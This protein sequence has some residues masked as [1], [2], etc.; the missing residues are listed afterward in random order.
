MHSKHPKEDPL[1][2]MGYEVRDAEMK[3]IGVATGIFFAFVVVSFA[4]GFG[5]FAWLNPAILHE[6]TTQ[7]PFMSNAPKPPYPLLQ[8]N[9]TTKTDIKELRQG[10]TAQL[11]TSAVLDA[12]K[13]VY[14][15]PIDRAIDLV[16]QRGLPERPSPNVVS[17]PK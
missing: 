16:A 3:T 12:K 17:G 11:T 1:I 9:I 2:D 7:A 5:I 10:E 14:R 4:I 15:I 6:K 13:G 8:T